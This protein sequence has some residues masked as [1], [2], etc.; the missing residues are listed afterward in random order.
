MANK[1]TVA[2][3]LG[4]VVSGRSDKGPWA[5]AIIQP[6]GEPG[7]FDVSAFDEIAESLIEAGEGAFVT[8]NGKLWRK[9]DNKTERWNT[10]I[11]AESVTQ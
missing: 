10:I 7:R 5:F 1:V 3:T 11:R 9:K 6:E 2:G 4:K 8:V